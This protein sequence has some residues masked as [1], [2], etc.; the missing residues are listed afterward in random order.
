MDNLTPLG[1]IVRISPR[2]VHIDDPEF[3]DKLYTN[4]TKFDKD[5]WYYDFLNRS[6]SIFGTSPHEQ[7]RMRRGPMAKYF[8]ASGINKIDPLVTEC[9][10]LLCQRIEEHRKNGQTVNLSNA[11][12]SLAMDV[13]SEYA[14][15]SPRRLLDHPTLG[16]EH[17]LFLRNI[18]HISLWNRH[19]P[20]ILPLFDL[21]P[22][23]LVAASGDKAALD[24]FDTMGYQKEQAA[25]IV[26][27]KGAPLSAAQAYPN[28]MNGVYLS[29]LPAPEKTPR[30][31]FEESALLV[32]AGTETTG[33]FILGPSPHF[34]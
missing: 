5:P 6:G 24:L 19:F 18:T 26:A 3:F 17:A 2:E 20:F 4:T 12:R 27:N 10:A 14:L 8:S 15:P 11:F 33:V 23:S 25:L 30:R 21:M 28:I 16:S 9:I 31:L 13:V 1:P 34:I 7:H 32:G 22:R 29:D